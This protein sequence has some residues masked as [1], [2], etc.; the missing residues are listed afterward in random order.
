MRYR[1]KSAKKGGN[2]IKIMVVGI[3][4]ATLFWFKFFSKRMEPKIIA[5]ARIKADTRI[6]KL[7]NNAINDSVNKIDNN[8]LLIFNKNRNGE[9]ILAEYNLQETYKLMNYFNNKMKE[10]NNNFSFFVSPGLASKDFL[11]NYIGNK[12]PI[13]IKMSNNYYTNLKTKVTDYGFNNA[14]VE[15]YLVIEIKQ[16]MIIPFEKKTESKKYELLISNYFITGKVPDFYG[17]KYTT[18]SNIFDINKKI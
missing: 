2:F 12:I 17:E 15:V 7:L 9:I 16:Q 5:E 4:I 8:R 3:V 11:L 6:Y 13:K 10:S 14:M 18:L 1:F